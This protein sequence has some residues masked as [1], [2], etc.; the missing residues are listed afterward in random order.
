[1]SFHEIGP[2]RGQ[3]NLAHAT[4]SKLCF[5]RQPGF[6]FR[7]KPALTP[8]RITISQES[9]TKPDGAYVDRF[10]WNDFLHTCNSY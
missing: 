6:T 9:P 3:P 4:R 10:K 5:S 8:T 1:M 7:K 2:C